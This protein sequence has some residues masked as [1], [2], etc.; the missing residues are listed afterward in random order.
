[1]IYLRGFCRKYADDRIL[2]EKYFAA[3]FGGRVASKSDIYLIILYPFYNFIVVSMQQ[4]K[5]DTGMQLCK[6]FD[7]TRQPLC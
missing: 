6:F 1:M 5:T 4:L 2:I 3:I 7:D